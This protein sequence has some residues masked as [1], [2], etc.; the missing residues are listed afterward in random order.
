MRLGQRWSIGKGLDVW[1]KIQRTSSGGFSPRCLGARPKGRAQT[2]EVQVTV[3]GRV[4]SYKLGKGFY[5]Y[6]Q[7]VAAS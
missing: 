4:A 3:A 1:F 6:L 5:A 7:V 2:N